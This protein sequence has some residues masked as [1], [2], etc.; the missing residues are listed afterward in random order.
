MSAAVDLRARAWVE[1]GTA[2]LLDQVDRA[3]AR[4]TAGDAELLPGWGVTHL[5]AHVAFN[6]EALGRLLTWARTG[7][8]TP[9]Y[10]SREARAAE[11]EEGAAR[12]V[13]E[14]ASHVRLSAR[15]LD[16]MIAAMPPE[17]WAA[18]V[19]TAQ[20]RTV[21]A[22]EVL[23]LRTREVWIHA[24]DLSVDDSLGF[25]DFPPELLNALV[26]DVVG[27]FSRR[28]QLSGLVVVAGDADTVARVEGSS[29]EP[30]TVRGPLAELAAWLTG[31]SDGTSLLVDGG[32]PLPQLPA[33][34]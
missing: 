33:W 17:A 3:V 25:A 4:G 5:L 14:N 31:R 11:I 6:A 32:A 1:E 19:R 34:L 12:P 28:G 9:M 24:V 18:E 16:E 30:V 20:G 2:V 21:P 7:V 22:S 23:W 8:E 26:E 29:G 13:E 10:P 15:A 27:M